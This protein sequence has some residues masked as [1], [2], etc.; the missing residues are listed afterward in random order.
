MMAFTYIEFQN[1]LLYVVCETETFTYTYIKFQNNLLYM[2]QLSFYFFDDN[3][4]KS[5]QILLPL[6]IAAGFDA[7]G[8]M[9]TFQGN[10]G[11][12][13]GGTKWPSMPQQ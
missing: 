10:P 3:T 13:E 8:P 1:N 5:Y 7:Q 12:P 9:D 2:K 6:F 11:L 4:M